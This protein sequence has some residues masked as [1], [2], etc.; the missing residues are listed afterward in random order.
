MIIHNLLG[1]SSTCGDGW[2]YIFEENHL[3]CPTDCLVESNAV[4]DSFDKSG[5]LGEDTS[6][7]IFAGTTI[8]TVILS[9]LLLMKLV[10][11]KGRKKELEKIE[12]AHASQVKYENQYSETLATMASSKIKS[13][14][15]REDLLFSVKD[16][17]EYLSKESSMTN[18]F[19]LNDSS[20]KSKKSSKPGRTTIKPNQI[21]QEVEWEI[22]QSNSTN[23]STVLISSKKSSSN[24]QLFAEAVA[25]H[26][27]EEA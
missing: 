8:I 1:K 5:S 24:T 15:S 21:R 25:R 7:F 6:H 3:N 23:K 11:W 2:C 4:N 16:G 27:R 26:L 18:A 19:E 17:N 9:T 20:E 13:S 14:P 10:A 12:L 22:T